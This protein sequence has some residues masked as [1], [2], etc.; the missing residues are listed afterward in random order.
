MATVQV[1]LDNR[2]RLIEICESQAVAKHRKELLEREQRQNDKSIRLRVCPMDIRTT[3]V[4]VT[5]YCI[6]L[7]LGNTKYRL[8]VKDGE[9]KFTAPPLYHYINGNVILDE[10]PSDRLETYSDIRISL[11]TRDM[12][13]GY[14]VMGMIRDLYVHL[15]G[16]AAIQFA[17]TRMEFKSKRS[18]GKLS[19][20]EDMLTKRVFELEQRLF[21][22]EVTKLFDRECLR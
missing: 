8:T 5:V 4:A 17:R 11:F 19:P 18:T 7:D 2:D 15:I 9:F 21:R 13:H 1:I 14:K 10:P 20:E 3:P 12:V 6:Y 16:Q 22:D